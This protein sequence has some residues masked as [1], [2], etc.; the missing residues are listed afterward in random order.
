MTFMA[1]LMF[2]LKPIM[3]PLGWL[4]DKATKRQYAKERRRREERKEE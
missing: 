3:M 4:A 2:I 1:V